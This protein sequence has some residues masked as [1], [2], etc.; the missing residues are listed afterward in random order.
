MTLFSCYDNL[1]L[2]PVF[3]VFDVVCELRSSEFE[4][5]APVG[6]SAHD[7]DCPTISQIGL[8]LSIHLSLDG[9]A[10]RVSR[11]PQCITCVSSSSSTSAPQQTE[12]T[13]V[14]TR[15]TNWSPYSSW[16]I[17]SLSKVSQV[18]AHSEQTS[19]N[20][21]STTNTQVKVVAV[22]LLA[23]ALL[24]RELTGLCVLEVHVAHRP[25]HNNNQSSQG[26]LT[27]HF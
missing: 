2:S 25:E 20:S 22:Y 27:R 13:Y 16:S 21:G 9:L 15:S 6:I 18:L 10:V 8:H 11:R 3:A 26:E 14:L 23:N 4:S 17:S 24:V 1:W 7:G 19:S 5:L 12:R